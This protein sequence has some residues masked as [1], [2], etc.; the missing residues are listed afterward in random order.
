MNET[1]LEYFAGNGKVCVPAFPGDLVV[2]CDVYAEV[3]RMGVCEDVDVHG[4]VSKVRIRDGGCRALTAEGRHIVLRADLKVEPA[5]VVESIGDETWPNPRDVRAS[6][7]P[8]MHLNE[9]VRRTCERY[10]IALPDL[11]APPT[12]ANNGGTP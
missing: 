3:W 1:E 12:G 7:L 4:A 6:L 5:A 10:G 11:S 2:W 8:F 9:K